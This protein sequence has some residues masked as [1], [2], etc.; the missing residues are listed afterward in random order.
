MNGETKMAA[1]IGPAIT[2][3]GSVEAIAPLG[4]YVAEYHH[5]NGRTH[6]YGYGETIDVA[7]NEARRQI[8]GADATMTRYM[9]PRIRCRALSVDEA[10]ELLEYLGTPWA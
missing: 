3:N 10:S 4:G 9:M 7:R 2:A 6:P 5:D 8:S 1:T